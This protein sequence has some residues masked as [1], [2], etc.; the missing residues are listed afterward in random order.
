MNPERIENANLELGAPRNWDIDQHGECRALGVMDDGASFWSQWRPSPD[1][2][3]ALNAGAPVFLRVFGR[4]HPPVA[5]M[6]GRTP[7]TGEP[8]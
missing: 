5:V 7:A 3:A 1:E 4:S 2:L 6:A 8:Q